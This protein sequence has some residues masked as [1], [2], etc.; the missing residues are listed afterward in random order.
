MSKELVK[1]LHT[2]D[3]QLDAPFGFLGEKGAAHRRQLR[4]TLERIV[5]LARDDDYDLLLIA[6]DLFNSNS[7]DRETVQFV[8]RHLG[9]L[10]IPVCILPGNHD[11]LGERSVYRKYPFPSNVRIFDQRPTY[12]EFPEHDLIIAAAP[13]IS[14]S[15]RRP[16]LRDIERPED[17]KWFVVMGHGNLQIPGHIESKARPIQ[18]E[19]IAACGADYVALGDWHSFADYS[20]GNVKAFYAGAPE[21]TA[22]NQ[23]G[24]G[25]VAT[26][27]LSGS[28]TTVQSIQVGRI[29]VKSIDLD[30]SGLDEVQIIERISQEADSNLMLNVTLT[31]LK[32][33]D[34]ILD[35]QNVQQAVESVFYFLQVADM[36]T[37]A[38]DSIDDADYPETYVIGQYVRLLKQKIELAPTE[39]DKR[40]AEQ[41]LQLGVAQLQGREVLR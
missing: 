12:Y 36:T 3:I 6:G 15:D 16:P 29:S 30:V 28:G 39:Q 37:T 32:E 33:I 14:P 1:L 22:L 23:S 11:Y 21:P 25:K 13:L 26:V 10:S 5:N 31:G 17:V 7:P 34:Q 19:E 35:P 38:L 24:A 2:A 18:R 27:T 20:Q 40:I 9:Q 41:A 8:T 4:R